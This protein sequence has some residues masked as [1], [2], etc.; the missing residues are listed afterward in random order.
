MALSTHRYYEELFV[1][2]SL[3]LKREFENS[4]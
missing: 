3:E 1:I 4:I 2:C